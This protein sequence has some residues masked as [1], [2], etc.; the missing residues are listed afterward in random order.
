LTGSALKPAS[1]AK[2]NLANESL[3]LNRRISR[4]PLR[5]AGIQEHFQDV[6][7]GPEEEQILPLFTGIISGRKF[8]KW[9]ILFAVVYNIIFIPLQFGYRIDFEGFYLIFEVFTVILY[10]CDIYFR[11]RNLRML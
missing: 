7:G 8:M 4:V 9:S 11:L 5:A 2:S 6:G 3:R 1:E 10:C